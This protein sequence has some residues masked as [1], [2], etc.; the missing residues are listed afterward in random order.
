MFPGHSHS[1][2]DVELL[3]KSWDGNAVLKGIQSV[4]DARRCVADG[5]RGVVS[6]HGWR[7]QD[8]GMSSLGMLLHI[9]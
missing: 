1:W 5:M 6:V 4:A 7:Q 8:G 2:E 3:K 9:L